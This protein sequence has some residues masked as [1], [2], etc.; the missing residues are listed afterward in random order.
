MTALAL[1]HWL[2]NGLPTR[3]GRIDEPSRDPP[4]AAEAVLKDA[5]LFLHHAASTGLP[6]DP[7]VRDAIIT[8]RMEI[9][10]GTLGKEHLGDLYAAYSS[11][12]ASGAG[13][14]DTEPVKSPA[15]PMVRGLSAGGGSQLRTRL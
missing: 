13:Y 11:F 8:A 6:I 2:T 14:P 1:W 7:T 3:E 4:M 10:S 5:E 15:E 12:H 9:T